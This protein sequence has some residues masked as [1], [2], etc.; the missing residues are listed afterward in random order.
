MVTIPVTWDSATRRKDRSVRI[1]FTTN[2]EISNADFAAMDLQVQTSG[3]LGYK[4]NES[5]TPEDLP[6]EDAPTEGG[7][8]KLQ[9]LRAVYFLYWRDKSDQSEPFNAYWDRMFEKIMDKAKEKLD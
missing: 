1:A 9:R 8:S 7:K 6:Q 3:W 5:L 2:L 4:Q